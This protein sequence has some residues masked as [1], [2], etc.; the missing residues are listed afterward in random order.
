MLADDGRSVS[1][2]DVALIRAPHRAEVVDVPVRIGEPRRKGESLAALRN[3]DLESEERALRSELET[4]RA[5]T[6]L[7]AMRS[8]G[9]ATMAEADVRQASAR[10][11]Q[12]GDDLQAL[13][14]EAPADGRVLDVLVRETGRAVEE[15]EPVLVYASGS[16]E[17]VFHVRMFEF[18]S[19]RLS[20]GESIE[21]RAAA[22]PERAVIGRVTHIG[23]VATRDVASR[24]SAL[25]P[26]GLVPVNA[27]TG[28]AADP[29]FEIRLRLDPQDAALAGAGL[30]ARFPAHYRTTAQVL[31]RRVK[32]FLNTVREG[33]D[34]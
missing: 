29:Y 5:R 34:G 25:A 21:C 27:A 16:P 24:V 17:A 30:R 8:P 32:R 26:G 22:H 14:I 15:G 20:V 18:E 4:A 1:F 23:R 10:L 28:E 7:A 33:A 13:E 2:E 31:E 12:V 9:E 6:V 11:A 3:P 19:L